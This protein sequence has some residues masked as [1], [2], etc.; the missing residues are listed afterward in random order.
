MSFYFFLSKKK[1]L[2]PYN[3]YG[4]LVH[5]QKK[6]ARTASPSVIPQVMG[7][8]ISQ[9]N[10]MK[11]PYC[12]SMYYTS[13]I[14]TKLTTTLFAEISAFFSIAVSVLSIGSLCLLSSSS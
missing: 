14:P 7:S 9:E 12:I 1:S 3:E 13:I 5:T 4:F 2:R 8:M 11:V 10:A 6:Y